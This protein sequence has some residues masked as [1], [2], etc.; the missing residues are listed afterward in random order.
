MGHATAH[1]LLN[2]IYSVQFYMALSNNTFKHATECKDMVERNEDNVT[3]DD[4][5]YKRT[6]RKHV[7]Y[8]KEPAAYYEQDVNKVLQ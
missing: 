1:A 8:L 6:S 5:F 3:I 7:G 2:I 4:L